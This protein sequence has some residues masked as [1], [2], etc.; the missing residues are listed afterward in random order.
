MQPGQ[1]GGPKDQAGGNA[2]REEGG[3]LPGDADAGCDQDL[4]MICKQD[5]DGDV[6]FSI[7]TGK[8]PV[9]TPMSPSGRDLLPRSVINCAHAWVDAGECVGCDGDQNLRGD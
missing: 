7:D 5:Q 8:A 1:K 2:L 3:E 6:L 4:A 9:L